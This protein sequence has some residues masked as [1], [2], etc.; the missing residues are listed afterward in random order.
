[1][2]NHEYQNGLPTPE[3]SRR[4][5]LKSAGTGFGFLALSGLLGEQFGPARGAVPA[6][7]VS[8][9]PLVAKKPHFPARA[10]RIIFLFMNGAI[11]QMDTF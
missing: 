11:S 6:T 1:M 7:P 8:V 2:S 3:P 10:K 9:S 5:V 4:Q